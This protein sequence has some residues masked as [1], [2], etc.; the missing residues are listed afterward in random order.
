VQVYDSLLSEGYRVTYVRIP[1]T[2]GA[3]PLP[4]DFD[5]FYSAAAGAGPS[6]ALIY[7]CQVGWRGRRGVAQACAQSCTRVV[8]RNLCRYRLVA[9]NLYIAGHREHRVCIPVLSA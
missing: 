2:D 6:D 8:D 1:L 4:R 3:C 5:T 9:W 7:T